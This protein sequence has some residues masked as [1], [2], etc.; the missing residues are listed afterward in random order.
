M[1]QKI[2]TDN[3]Q[4]MLR[5]HHPGE[6]YIAILPQ[7]SFIIHFFLDYGHYTF[8]GPNMPL[9]G[10]TLTMELSKE[11]FYAE[12][13]IRPLQSGNITS[14][15]MLQ[16]LEL[17][18]AIG[19][20]KK[21]LVAIEIIAAALCSTAVYSSEKT[22]QAIDFSE[23]RNIYAVVQEWKETHKNIAGTFNL[24][25]PDSIT[26]NR[27]LFLVNQLYDSSAS[28]IIYRL[29]MQKAIT[30]LLHSNEQ[31][32]AI[33]EILGYT[34]KENFITAFRNTYGVTP[35]HLRR[36]FRWKTISS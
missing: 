15:I 18:K 24:Y 32:N 28:E 22:T 3:F 25:K 7:P 34:S 30:L 31:I 35:G 21:D 6:K 17:I 20:P 16:V 4:V 9:E 2:T 23:M 33:S 1:E 27:F 36:Q 19:Q 10:F 13:G 11:I 12:P 14:G 29:N 5:K 8:S 26:R